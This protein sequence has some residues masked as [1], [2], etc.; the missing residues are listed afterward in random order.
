MYF[1][2][3]SPEDYIDVCNKKVNWIR[4]QSGQ[5]LIRGSGPGHNHF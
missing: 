1:K 3:F 2:Q 4:I 5:K